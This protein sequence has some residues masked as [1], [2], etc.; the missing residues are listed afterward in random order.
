[1]KGDIVTF[2]TQSC[3]HIRRTFDRVISSRKIFHKQD[4]VIPGG[5]VEV[6]VERQEVVGSN[7]YFISP[8]GHC[9]LLSISPRDQEVS[10]L[11]V[12]G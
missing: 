11:L 1:M 2:H 6:K 3:L 4:P 7:K 8:A 10:Q 5:W 12:A 9:F